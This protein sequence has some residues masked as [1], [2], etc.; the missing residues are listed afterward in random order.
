MFK[1][2]LV[3][4]GTLC[5]TLPLLAE[6]TAASS[7][8]GLEKGLVALGAGIA[9]AFAAIGGG[10]GQGRAAAAAMEGTARNPEAGKRIFVLLILALALIESLV[11]Y[12]LVVAFS[13]IG[14]I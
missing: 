9:I 3:T 10:I 6:E 8:G 4:L 2:A 7:I 12:A 5:V 11:I 1:K 13:L 14:K